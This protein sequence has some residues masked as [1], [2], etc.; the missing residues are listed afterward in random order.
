MSDN[1]NAHYP[2]QSNKQYYLD[3]AKHLKD[4]FNSRYP[5]YVYRRRPNNSRRKRRPDAAPRTSDNKKAHGSE[6]GDE[7]GNPDVDDMSQTDAED[8]LAEAVT[9]DN[10]YGRLEGGAHSS[11]D[12]ASHS[13]RTAS[14]GYSPDGGG[15]RQPHGRMPYPSHR[16]TPP[17]LLLE[18]PGPLS[19]PR[20]GNPQH[21]YPPSHQESHTHSPTM[22][23]DTPSNT[24]D[25]P[26]NGVSRSHH[27]R[28]TPAGWISGATDRSSI[29]NLGIAGERGLSSYPQVGHSHSSWT[30]STSPG[31]RRASGAMSPSF[32]FPTLNSPFFPNQSHV[33]GNFGSSATSSSS[34]SL[35]GGASG[36]APHY[37]SSNQHLGLSG[38]SNSGYDHR[39]Y[40]SSPTPSEPYPRTSHSHRDLNHMYQ[41]HQSHNSSSASM[42]PLS[43]SHL[44]PSSNTTGYWS[45]DK[46][47][48]GH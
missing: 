30:R 9:Q 27:H 7:S 8:P 24:W 25:A 43:V 35:G 18:S 38:R 11:Y 36:A 17:D 21:S 20:H 6:Q 34:S 10:R 16:G 47:D 41:Q 42:S 13:S 23:D 46:T 33:Q 3:Q 26:H 39:S 32:S 28:T 1:H 12:P 44:N 29:S 4:I 19:Q 48:S 22:Y 14:Y 15:Y 5:D 31:P 40:T 45:R 2:L 37:H